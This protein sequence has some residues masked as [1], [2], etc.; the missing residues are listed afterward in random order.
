MSALVPAYRNR[1]IQ[2][3]PFI[4]TS[5]AFGARKDFI[6]EFFCA[7]QAQK[8]LNNK[9]HWKPA[10]GPMRVRKRRLNRPATGREPVDNFP[11]HLLQ[12]PYEDARRAFKRRPRKTTA[13]C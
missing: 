5:R 13:H 12:W 7:L 2:K 4:V 8:K 10:C 6:V 9:I 1:A 11:T 3:S